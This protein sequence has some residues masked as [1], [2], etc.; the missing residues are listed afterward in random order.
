MPRNMQK[1]MRIFKGQHAPKARLAQ[2]LC[3]AWGS[4]NVNDVTGRPE[5]H[6]RE[7]MQKKVNKYE[8]LYGLEAT[9]IRK[10]DWARPYALSMVWGSMLMMRSQG[11][12]SSLGHMHRNINMK[13]SEGLYA[14]GA[15][16]I[17]AVCMP[18]D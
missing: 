2:I 6:Q 14:L 3:M 16:V 15:R 11:D 17:Q 4:F 7:N 5:G 1:K 10:Q 9:E 18:W 8:G 12:L 13:T